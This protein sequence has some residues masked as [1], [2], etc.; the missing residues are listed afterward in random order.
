M[1]SHADIARRFAEIAGTGGRLLRASGANV[2]ADDRQIYSYGAHFPMARIMLDDAGQRSWWL[3]NGDTY[4]VSTS[5]HQSHVRGALASTGL[6]MLIV[7]FSCLDEAH[8]DRD[9]IVP[10]EITQDR[11][12]STTHHGA[13]LAD[14]PE[15]HR[16]YGE[17]SGSWVDGYGYHVE[18]DGRYAWVTR[19]HWLGASVFRATYQQPGTWVP[20]DEANREASER[21]GKEITTY[22]RYVEGER[23]TASFVSAFDDQERTPLYFLAELPQPYA[24]ETVAEAMDVLKPSEVWLAERR[25]KSI[26][27]QGDVFAVPVDITTRELVKQAATRDRGVRVLGVNHTATEVITVSNTLP[28]MPD[29]ES[30][31]AT[32]A[33]GTL[34]HAPE[35]WRQPEHRMQRMGDGKTWHLLVKNTVPVDANGRSRSWSRGGRVD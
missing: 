17:N 10:V 24:P 22:T 2:Y 34:R 4:S 9:S 13:E 30:T 7:P 25:G 5:Q 32:Y 33:R 16:V 3:V 15:S 8:I 11:Y 28:G 29:D 27:R 6:P 1:T 12:E 18:D 21:H 20:D 31:V 23:V 26:T 35:R 19:R 14:V